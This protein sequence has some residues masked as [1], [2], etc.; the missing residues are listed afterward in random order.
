MELEDSL[1]YSQEHVTDHYLVP[2]KSIRTLLSYFFKIYYNIMPIYACVSEA[3][4]SLRVFWLE[5]NVN[6]TILYSE[7]FKNPKFWILFHSG[8]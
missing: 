1:S 5:S 3:V 7:L 6:Q 2:D 4:G 8:L